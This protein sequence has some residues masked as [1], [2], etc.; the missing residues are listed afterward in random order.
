MLDRA[1]ARSRRCG[2]WRSSPASADIFIAGADIEE[3]V[4]LKTAAEAE[5]LSRD[6][7][8]MLDRVAAF[9]KP[10]RR[11]ASTAPAWAAGSSS[12]SPA[13]TASPPII[14]RPSSACP[15]CSS[16][17][18]RGAGGC[19]R[20]P[21]LIGARAAL[22]IILAG[23]S[24]RAAKAFRLGI[25]DEL[26][27]PA[28]LQDVTLAAR[29]ADGRAAA[30]WRASGAADSSGLLLDGNPLGRLLVFRHGPQAGARARRRATT[31]RRSPRSRPSRTACATAWR[32]AC[33]AR[34]SSSASSP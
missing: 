4:R 6:G 17:S 10:D 27:P 19:Q 1:G 29:A 3:F 7:Q 2:P 24:E 30:S 33:S 13:A 32:P 31:P 25:V 11:R 21:R 16:A 8:E 18:S 20:L 9:P 34:P 15:R 23:K 22:D 12:R 28:I 5:Q 26:V 14:P